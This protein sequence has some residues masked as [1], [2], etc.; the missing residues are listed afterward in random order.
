MWF[1]FNLMLSIIYNWHIK[2]HWFSK[3]KWILNLWAFFY[4]VYRLQQFFINEKRMELLLSCI[5]GLTF[6]QWKI[7]YPTKRRLVFI[8]AWLWIEFQKHIKIGMI[9]IILDVVCSYVYVSWM[10]KMLYWKRMCKTFLWYV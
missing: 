1:I 3:Y 8:L 10:K 2:I 7:N 9:F 4:H 6:L 5:H